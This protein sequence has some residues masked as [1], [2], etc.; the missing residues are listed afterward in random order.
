MNDLQATVQA[1]SGVPRSV[2]VKYV[3]FFWLVG[4][5]IDLFYSSK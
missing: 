4:S 2:Q 5:L 1:S 3:C